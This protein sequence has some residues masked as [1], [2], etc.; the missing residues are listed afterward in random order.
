MYFLSTELGGG[1]AQWS[2][3]CPP[4]S[5]H[6][7]GSQFHSGSKKLDAEAITVNEH[8]HYENKVVAK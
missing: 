5:I 7:S 1:V 6:Y 2:D 3:F 8:T 4:Y